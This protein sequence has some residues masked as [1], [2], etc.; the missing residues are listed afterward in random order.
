[1]TGRGRLQTPRARDLGTIQTDRTGVGVL[2]FGTKR[3]RTRRV[4]IENAQTGVFLVGDRNR[5]A[6]S[7][8]TDIGSDGVVVIGNRNRVLKNDIA[9][10][11]VDGV[12]IDGDDNLVRGGAFSDMPIG[13]WAFAGAG[14]RAEQCEFLRVPEPARIGG[15][16]TLLPEFAAP[17]TTTCASA[18]DCNDANECTTDTCDVNGTCGNAAVTDGTLC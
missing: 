7:I 15:V 16:R 2:A 13:I 1:N 4:T 18:L 12:F 17:F 11:S 14:N 3:V 10:S 5:I 8:M 9:V 6:G